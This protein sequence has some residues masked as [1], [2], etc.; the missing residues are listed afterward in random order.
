MKLSAKTFETVAMFDQEYLADIAQAKLV[1][2]GIRAEV[3]EGGGFHWN[4][5][6]TA[7]PARFS[8]TVPAKSAKK[9][10]AI[11]GRV[12]GKI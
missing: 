7:M 3:A 1:A 2:A 12:R 4:P 5:F 10:K 8:V 6:A 9:A 11:L